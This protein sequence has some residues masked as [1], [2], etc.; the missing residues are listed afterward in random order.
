MFVV[1]PFLVGVI[2]SLEPDHITAVSVLASER[3]LSRQK[4]TFSVLSASLKWA[5]GHG[6]TLLLFSMLAWFF[7]SA[8]LIK[9]TQLS[10][11]AEALVGLVMIWLGSLA[12]R[13]NHRLKA[14]LKEHKKIEP[15]DHQP[16][17][18]LH[19]H[20]KKGEE[21]AVNPMSRSFWVGML[22]G[23]AGSGGL[24]TSV[25][26]LQAE[27]FWQVVSI[28]LLESLG[29]LA[30]IALYAYVLGYTTSRFVEHNMK[31]LKWLNAIAGLLSIGLGMHMLIQ[32]MVQTLPQLMPS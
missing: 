26:V 18:L 29:I 32:F 1:R 20:G 12:I 22:H 31:Y 25:L 2:H 13:R 19:I 28:I 30:A 5:V 27:T 4:I 10:F 21:I 23:L 15:H 8:L 7:K 6:F 9:I 24:I 16:G 3:V 14:Q 17:Q 11:S